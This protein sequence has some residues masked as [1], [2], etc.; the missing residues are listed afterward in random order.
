LINNW[1]SIFSHNNKHT[2]IHLNY[3]SIYYAS[4]ATI[5]FFWIL[6]FHSPFPSFRLVCTFA[7]PLYK[8]SYHAKQNHVA[9][10]RFKCSWNNNYQPK[11]FGERIIKILHLY[12]KKITRSI[13]YIRGNDFNKNLEYFESKKSN[14]WPVLDHGI[15]RRWNTIPLPF[16]IWTGAHIFVKLQQN[17]LINH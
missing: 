12:I 11:Q 4:T 8:T 14:K 16:A 1:W 15:F 17:H 5:F 6:L 9:T 10:C 3:V 2:T 7:R 13:K